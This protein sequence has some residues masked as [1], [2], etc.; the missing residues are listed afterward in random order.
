MDEC[1]DECIDECMEQLYF[2]K[3]VALDHDFVS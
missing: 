1:M 2:F 3:H